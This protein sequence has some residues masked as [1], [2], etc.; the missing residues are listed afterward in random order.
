MLKELSHKAKRTWTAILVL[1]LVSVASWLYYRSHCRFN[2]EDWKADRGRTHMVSSIIN[3][4]LLDNKSYQ[5]VIDILGNP[6]YFEDPQPQF[7]VGRLGQKRMVYY[8][9]NSSFMSFESLMVILE[10]DTVVNVYTTYRS[11]SWGL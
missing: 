8:T 10:W 9:G 2:E 3:T 11:S 1:A 4:G 6:H 5:E 7:G